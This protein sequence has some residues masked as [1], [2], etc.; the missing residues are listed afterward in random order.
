LDPN[1]QQLTPDEIIS[2]P[3]TE[4]LDAPATTEVGDIPAPEATDAT[5]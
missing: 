4:P 5:A 3:P 2:E 1:T